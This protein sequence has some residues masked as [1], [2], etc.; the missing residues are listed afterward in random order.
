MGSSNENSAFG[1]ARNPWALDRI[2]GG[3]SGG[4]AAAVA[5]RHGAAGARL[6]H[7]RIDPPAGRAVRRRRPEADLRPRLALRPARVRLVARSDRPA[8]R[9]PRTMRRSRSACIAGRDPADATSAPEPVPDYTAALTGD[10]RGTAHRRA[11]RAARRRRRCRR[12][13][14]RSTTALDV[15][16]GARRDARRHRAAA[17][18][19]TPSR[20]TTWSR[21]PRRARTWRATTACAT[22][23]APPD[24][25]TDAARRCT[26]GRATQGFGAEVKRRIMLGTYVLSAGYYDAYYLKAQQV[27]T[28]IRRD[29][30][31]A[32]EHV[33]VVA[34][35]T[36]PTPAF[37]SASAST[38]RCRCTWRTS[39]RSAR[40]SPGCPRSAC[41]CGFTRGRS[42]RSGCS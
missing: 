9:A 32:F 11:A 18:A 38:I 29:Y 12:A 2:P 15:L 40:T 13:R 23:S 28:L 10:V 6:G 4:S 37:G 8:R 30:D 27:R 41:P 34:M 31:R 35:P 7:R 19:G 24:D 33:D 17:R 1:P 39:S 26:R 5:A 36:S 16:R 22:D 20:S 14:A 42:C 3:S 25:A 21:P